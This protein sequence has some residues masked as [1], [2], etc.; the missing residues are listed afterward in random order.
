MSRTLTTAALLGAATI[1]AGWTASRGETPPIWNASEPPPWAEHGLDRAPED[2][3]LEPELPTAVGMIPDIGAFLSHCPTLDP[4]YGQIRSDF[5]IRRNGFLVGS[6]SCSEPVSAMTAVEYSDPLIVLQGLRVM[7]YMDRGLSGHLPWTPGTLYQWVKSKIGGI[8]IR[9]GSG[10]YCC[11]TYGSRLFMVVGTQ[12]DFNR[13]FDKSWRGIAGN[14]DLYAHEARHV[15]GFPHVS[16]CGINGGCDQQ[17]QEA[18]PS[19]YGIQYQLNRLW[20]DGGINVGFACLAQPERQETVNWHAGAVSSFR[21]R[22]CTSLPPVVS[23]PAQ[24]G[25]VCPATATCTPDAT[26]LC[27]DGRYRVRVN[28]STTQGGG[29]SGAG[30]AI[31]LDSLGVTKG[32]LFWF[33][34]ADNPELLVK[35]LNGCGLD[36]YR[37]V[38]FS[39]GTNVGFVLTVVDTQNGATRTY[40]NPDRTPAEPLQDVAALPCN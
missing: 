19:P 2:L 36:G 18:N 26:T 35:V 4:A 17:Y 31:R 13:M 3:A 30:R 27:I 23:L 6:V 5:E 20:L 39:A 33:F 22:F 15:D 11:T 34:G 21:R 8:D 24:P 28:F 12:D 40:S 16:C 9:D 29:I 37:W 32:G 7:Y 25:G 10:A 1:A 38:Y 14:I